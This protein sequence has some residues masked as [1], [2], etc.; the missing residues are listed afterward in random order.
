[1][2]SVH[3]YVSL[4]LTSHMWIR[5]KI[6]NSLLPV[7]WGH[8]QVGITQSTDNEHIQNTTHLIHFQFY[9]DNC[10]M[11]WLLNQTLMLEISESP[12]IPFLFTRSP[13]QAIIKQCWIHTYIV[14][15]I[16][17]VL[18]SYNLQTSLICII[19]AFWVVFLISHKVIFLKYIK[20]IHLILLTW[21]S[22]KLPIL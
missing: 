21:K 20:A 10:S 22:E 16:L 19:T 1:M 18:K 13:I 12:L 11:S 2:L 5:Y 8:F 15:N 6:G 17:S 14:S 7:V 4:G 9:F 3:T